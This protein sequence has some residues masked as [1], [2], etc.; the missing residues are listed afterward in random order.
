MAGAC[1]SRNV[2]G[3]RL[4]DDPTSDLA[5]V[6]TCNRIGFELLLDQCFQSCAISSKAS[7]ILTDACGSREFVPGH[8]S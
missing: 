5:S 2:E 8:V 6:W 1:S 4:K 7:M 3:L